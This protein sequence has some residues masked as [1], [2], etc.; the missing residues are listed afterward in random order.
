MV[1]FAGFSMPL[2]YGNVGAGAHIFQPILLNPQKYVWTSRL[3]DF[4]SPSR[5]P[6]PYSQLRRSL[7]RWTHGPIQVCSSSITLTIPRPHL[8]LHPFNPSFRGPTAT[9]FL[10]HLT[11]SSL[12]TLATYT[13]TL[14]VLL[15]P[16]GGIIDDLIITKHAPDAY[17][18][19]TNA[20][21][22]D[23]DL[24][25]FASQLAHWNQ[26]DIAKKLGPVEHEVLDGWGLLALQGPEAAQYLQGLTSFDL[27]ELRF[28]TCAFV[29][30]EGFNLHVARGGYTGEDGFE[31]RSMF[32]LPLPPSACR[33]FQ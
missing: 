12:S 27:R 24:A 33:A 23:R 11:P 15:N 9:A 7:R 17:Y 1:P 19:V 28:G 10:E 30:I 8:R 26:S 3:T 5:I 29:P 31:V 6:P 20:G 4:P 22:R 21:R 18:V 32:Y 2:S 13:S 25:W 16:Q 14:S